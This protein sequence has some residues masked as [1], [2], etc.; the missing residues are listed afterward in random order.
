MATDPLSQL[1]EMNINKYEKAGSIAAKIL[2][3]IIKMCKPGVN[4]Y[5]I[6]KYADNEIIKQCNNVYKNIKSKGIA[7]PTTISLNNYAGN[8]LHNS[9]LKINEDDLVKIDLGVHIDGFPAL[10]AY[11]VVIESNKKI[12]DDKTLQE[13]YIK[14][15]NIL[16][17]TSKASKEILK[18]MK[19]GKTNQ[20]VQNV[21]KKYAEKYNVSLPFINEQINAPGI[22]SYQISK[23]IIDG[24]NDDDSEFIHHMIMSQSN[25]NYDFVMNETEFIE[26][27]VYCIDVMYC[28]GNG[29]LERDDLSTLIYKR[30]DKKAAL[31]LDASKKSLN[32]FN[33]NKFPINIEQFINSKFKLGLKECLD[34][35]LID[36]YP[37]I[38][39][40]NN[41]YVARLKFTVIVKDNPKL[42]T[43]RSL[44]AELDKLI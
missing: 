36:P 14:K 33:S 28:S 29:K 22:I 16:K 15:K 9:E 24:N 44:D 32:V 10:I 41:E 3:D 4:I 25:E 20:D 38:K 40:K 1:T 6:C 18:L 26:N 35:K 7:Y 13:S 21:F 8:Y 30:T 39:C 23:N 31:R 2:D 37:I 17:A 19:P 43:A 42:I 11:T 12:S 34:K 5:D 27:E